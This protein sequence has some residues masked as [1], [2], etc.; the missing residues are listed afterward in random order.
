MAEIVVYRKR[1]FASL[2]M[3]LIGVALGV[4][5]YL[6]TMLNQYGKLADGWFATLPE[7]IEAHDKPATAKSDDNAPPT[8]KELEEA[9]ARLNRSR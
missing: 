3:L 4:A 1:G 7:A 5:G 6:I 9:L 2:V 8:R